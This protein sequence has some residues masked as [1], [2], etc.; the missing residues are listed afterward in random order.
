MIGIL[1]SKKA[2][3][4]KKKKSLRFFKRAQICKWTFINFNNLKE[5]LPLH[6]NIIVTF[7]L[8]FTIKKKKKQYRNSQRKLFGILFIFIQSYQKI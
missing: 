2:H 6:V 1:K 5:N 3:L 8:F 7:I 4:E